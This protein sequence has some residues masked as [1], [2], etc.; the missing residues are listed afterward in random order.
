MLCCI[1]PPIPST[2]HVVMSLDLQAALGAIQ[3]GA[4]EWLEI[5]KDRK[6]Q[7][8]IGEEEMKPVLVGHVELDEGGEPQKQEAEAGEPDEGTEGK[9]PHKRRVTQSIV[10]LKDAKRKENIA[11]KEQRWMELTEGCKSSTASVSLGALTEMTTMSTVMSTESTAGSKGTAMMTVSSTMEGELV[12]LEAAM[13][14]QGDE[15]EDMYG[16]IYR[17]T[18]EDRTDRSAAQA[19]WKEEWEKQEKEQAAMRYA[20]QQLQKKVE[21]R[22]KQ[23]M[24]QV[25]LEEEE[26]AVEERHQKTE[27]RQKACLERK[28]TELEKQRQ[29]E[30]E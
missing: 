3:W 13:M 15:D 26:K 23:M 29:R 6:R 8:E 27:E 11:K 21:E 25:L 5:L 20:E 4:E 2:A 30:K 12:D 18:S 17:T 16:K 19:K 14:S 28:A 22:Q 7:L 10:V 24:E 9:I 1:D